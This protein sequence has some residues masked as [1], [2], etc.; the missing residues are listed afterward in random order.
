MANRKKRVFYCM[1]EPNKMFSNVFKMFSNVFAYD[2]THGVDACTACLPAMLCI[3]LSK[4]KKMPLAGRSR[5]DCFDRESLV[6]CKVRQ[7]E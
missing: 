1:I 6:I 7:T 5:L 4:E 3:D 2:V